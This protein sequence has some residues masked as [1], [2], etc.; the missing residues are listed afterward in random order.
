MCI[1]ILKS[2]Y[3]PDASGPW[4]EPCI[5]SGTNHKRDQRVR[6]TT[7]TCSFYTTPLP[8]LLV[9]FTERTRE[10]HSSLGI[11]AT[12]GMT[13]HQKFL[14]IKLIKVEGVNLFR[15]FACA[16]LFSKPIFAIFFYSLSSYFPFIYK[17]KHT[18][19]SK[20]SQNEEF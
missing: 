17:V 12:R 9:L 16:F 2:K 11:I 14:E 20:C 6:Q 13:F 15:I 1:F 4:L 3:I 5:L 7:L 19:S 10:M 18:P 8:F